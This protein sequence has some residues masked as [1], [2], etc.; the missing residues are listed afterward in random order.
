MR[1]SVLSALVLFLI[2]GCFNGGPSGNG[3]DDDTD[4]DIEPITTGS[5]YRPPVS[6]TWQWQLIGTVNTT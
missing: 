4:P 5:W 2:Y 6:A 3:G 1:I